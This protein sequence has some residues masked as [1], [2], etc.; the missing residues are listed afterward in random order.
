VR[1]ALAARRD[2]CTAPD[3]PLRIYEHCLLHIRF[4]PSSAAFSGLRP[5]MSQKASPF[6]LVTS[7]SAET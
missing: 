1:R 5:P 6:R 3:A 7:N 2:T 4:S